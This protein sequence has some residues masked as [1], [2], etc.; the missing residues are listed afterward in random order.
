MH[1]D[2]PSSKE[3]TLRFFE[4]KLELIEMLLMVFYLFP[5]SPVENQLQCKQSQTCL[6]MYIQVAGDTHSLAWIP[7]FMKKTGLFGED[8]PFSCNISKKKKLWIQKKNTHSNENRSTLYRRGF[9][10][11]AC[12]W[13]PS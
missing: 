4:P 10:L 6:I 7:Q 8:W 13:R 1:Y 11:I 3:S 2:F 5:S 9:T 12:W